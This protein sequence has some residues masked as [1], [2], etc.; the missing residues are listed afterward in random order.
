[1]SRLNDISGKKIRTV[2]GILSGTS[3]DAVDIVLTRISGHGLNTRIEVLGY[4]EYK[5]PRYLR[6]YV[7]KSSDPE[8]GSVADV[9]RLNVILARYYSKCILSGLKSFGFKPENVDIIGSHGQTI[10]HLPQKST[11]YGINS[12]STLQIGDPSVIANCTGIITIGDFRTADVGAGGSGAPLIPYLDYILFSDKTKNRVLLNIGGIS[13]V[14]ILKAGSNF[15]SVTAF[16]TGPGN[17]MI[18]YIAIKFFNKEFDKDAEFSQKGVLNKELFL[19]L[20]RSDK[21]YP[22][23]PPK[24]TGREYYSGAFIENILKKYNKLSAFDIIRTFTE[25]TSYTISHNIL[26]YSGFKHGFELIVSGGGAHNNVIISSLLKHL[27]EAE[28]CKIN[29]NGINPN[30]KE[31]VLF[32]VLANEAV[33]GIP[34]NLMKVTGSK[35]K[36]VLGKICQVV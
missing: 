20:K 9:C 35:R 4:K 3:V 5:I 8:L 21:Y 12:R 24:S 25:Y 29:L 19:E 27:P 13:N 10:H 7:L 16:D 18:D 31:A 6:N 11:F 14:T 17:M 33:S 1:M 22:K 34:A 2:I 30:N 32:A 36:T 23:K 28:I 26:K 15:E